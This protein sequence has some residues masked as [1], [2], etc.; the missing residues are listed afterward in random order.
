MTDAPRTTAELHPLLADR[1]STR[2]YDAAH[3]LADAEVD[4]LLEAARWA[5]SAANVQPW[6]FLLARRGE[7][8]F[9][10]LFAVLAAGNQLWAGSAS[11]LVLAVAETRT[12]DGAEQPW[13][14]YDLGQ[15]VAHLSIQAQ[16]D[17]LDVHQ[18]GGFDRAAAAAEFDLPERFVPF[19]VIAVGTH[20]P[21]LELP[22]PLAER[23]RAPRTRKPV[24]ELLLAA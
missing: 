5:P 4:R 15:A 21:G 23:E 3:E 22:A 19:T 8:A 2:A 13:A 16:A 18:L 17:G 9:D 11:A 20:A 6:R 14:A 12:E 7:A 24:S 10:R 1:R